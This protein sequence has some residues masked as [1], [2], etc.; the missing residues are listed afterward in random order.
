M[1]LFRLSDNE[2]TGECFSLNIYFKNIQEAYKLNLLPITTLE[3]E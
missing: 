3:C 1:L 2:T